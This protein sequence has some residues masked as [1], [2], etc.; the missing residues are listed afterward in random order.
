MILGDP[1]RHSAGFSPTES[2]YSYNLSCIL[3]GKLSCI[4]IQC[5][6]IYIQLYISKLKKRSLWSLWYD[7]PN[8]LQWSQPIT[9][10]YL[11]V[12]DMFW[13]LQHVF[14]RMPYFSNFH[15]HYWWLNFSSS[16]VAGMK[17]QGRLSRDRHCVW[18]QHVE[19]RGH[20]EVW[21]PVAQRGIDRFHLR[22]A[23][24]RMVSG[25]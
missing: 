14:S 7:S 23:C 3:K 6:Y 1:T 2:S 12:I 21:R 15:P 16:Q 9:S 22:C 5:M 25:L 24:H 17:I 18:R 4:C 19:A 10:L 11:N 13:L 8:H 20:Q